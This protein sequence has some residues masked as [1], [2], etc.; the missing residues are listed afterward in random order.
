MKTLPDAQVLFLKQTPTNP[1]CE[2]QGA[3]LIV[4]RPPREDH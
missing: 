3:G 1:E 2:Y 4:L